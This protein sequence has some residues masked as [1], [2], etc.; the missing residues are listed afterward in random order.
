MKKPQ[1][2][3]HYKK[4]VEK[5]LR[6]VP[7][8]QLALLIKKISSLATNPFPAGAVCLQGISNLYRIRHANYRVIY[9]VSNDELIILVVKVGHRKEV[10]RSI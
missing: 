8:V 4:S 7:K 5:E 10:Y 3:V 2:R 9:Q 1:H 6:K